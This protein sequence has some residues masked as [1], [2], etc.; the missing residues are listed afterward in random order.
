MRLALLSLSLGVPLPDLCAQSQPATDY[1]LSFDSSLR[2]TDPE[3]TLTHLK[4]SATSGGETLLD[5]PQQEAAT[6]YRFLSGRTVSVLP[7]DKVTVSVSYTGKPMHLYLYID[8]NEDG[9]FRN[10]LSSDGRPASDGEL[11]SYT[12]Y[13][14][15]NSLGEEVA[16]VSSVPASALPVFTLPAS[17]PA[18]MYRARLKADID[19]ADPAGSAGIV[20]NGGAVVDFLLN[21][22]ARSHALDIRSLNGSVYSYAN[23]ALP[24][25]V[26]PFR[27]LALMPTPV[28]KG[29]EAPGMTIRHGH[30]LDGPQYLHGNRQWSEF[31]VPAS[32]YTLPGDS[33]DGDL[34]VTV[35]YE[36]G[37]DALYRLVFS[38][39]FDAADGTQPD[40]AKW[41]RCPR[42]SSTWNRFHAQNE[43]GYALTGC[44]E[45][46]KFVARALYN[47][48][49]DTDPVPMITGAI[50]T[51]G[52][53]SYK[54]GWA[55]ARIRTMPYA[56]S[57]PAFWLMPEDGSLGWPAAGEID[58]WEQ[59]N[60]ENRAYH[61]VHSNWTYNEGE[62]NNPKSS[63]NEA[64]QMDRYHTYSL[65][66]DENSLKWYVDG[67][68]VGSYQR[69]TDPSVLDRGQ[70]PFDKA[71]YILINQS[72]GDGSWAGVYN[73][74]HVYE[75]YFDWVRVY[76]INEPTGIGAV[77][78]SGPDVS[79]ATAP[80]AIRL[81]ASSS[82]HVTVSDLAGRIVLAQTFKGH[83]TVG[84][85]RG[86]YIVNGQKILVP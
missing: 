80:S 3:N 73:P 38:D 69:S 9:A 70:W 75:T 59:I 10:D 43:E 1:P 60:T 46:G 52:K 34:R 20:S 25:A 61:T 84:V 21:V 54:Y 85:E 39:E 12:Y 81:H 77:S 28:A 17:L 26:T 11:L 40:A 50:M 63:F 31:T 7:G 86:V 23:A 44:Q 74:S 49:Q 48:F 32:R 42:Y 55:E 33:V 64:V 24:V 8:L 76:Q 78:S 67:K 83:R 16:D 51:E 47:P 36:A 62:T 4:F 45:G 30:R 15:R 66:W 19:N 56:G 5:L 37:A 79:V 68:Y 22:H 72:V 65:E 14:G 35:A 57:F 71:F 58:I 2:K 27:N 29:Y 82:T 18:G 13:N 53:F 6:V 41:V